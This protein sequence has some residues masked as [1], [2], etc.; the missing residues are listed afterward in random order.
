MFRAWDKLEKVTLDQAAEELAAKG[1]PP[2]L[3]AKFLG[4]T[5]SLL[6]I[7]GS[8]TK[9]VFAELGKLFTNGTAQKAIADLLQISQYV[10]AMG[11]P[12]TNYQIWPLLARGLDCYTRPIFETVFTAVNFGSATGGGRFDGLVQQL[13]GPDLPASGSSF[14]LER[15]MDLMESVGLR[16][17]SSQTTEV[18][19]TLFDPQDVALCTKTFEAA[20]RLRTAGFAVEVY[21]GE[22]PKLAKQPDIARKKSINLALILG[23]DELKQGKVAVKDLRNGQQMLVPLEEI[24]AYVGKVL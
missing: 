6:Q 11:V 16:P 13:G 10:A 4:V 7:C 23:P 20:A 19:V 9:T 15:I 18:F 14:G 21:T 12:Q 22:N 3:V 24:A 2:E 17:A 1:V 8:D 5:R